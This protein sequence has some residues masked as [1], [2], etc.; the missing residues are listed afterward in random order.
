MH[1]RLR[2]PYVPRS[3]CLVA[4][5][6]CKSSLSSSFCSLRSTLQQTP[7]SARCDSILTSS[8]LVT[9]VRGCSSNTTTTTN[10]TSSSSATIDTTKV[11]GTAGQEGGGD[12]VPLP[13]LVQ[14]EA[15]VALLRSIAPPSTT[16]DI[17]EM[18]KGCKNA[19][20]VRQVLE[21]VVYIHSLCFDV[22]NGH[23]FRVVVLQTLTNVAPRTGCMMEWFDCVDRFRRLGFVLTRSFVAEGLT[24]IR[25]WLSHEFQGKGRVPSILTDGTAHIKELVQWCLEDRLVFDHVL[26]TRIV[27]LLTMIVSFFDRQNLYR[28]S[29]PDDF[30]KRDGIVVEWVVTN[31]RCVDYDECVLQCDALV[32][33]LLEQ[34]RHHIPSRPPF[35]FMFRL[36][37][38]YFATDNVEKLIA[39]MEDAESYGVNVAESTTA[40]L[41]QL[42]CAFNYPQVPEL[43]LR[44]RVLLPQCVLA[45]PDIS[46]LLFYFSRSGGGQPCPHCGEP[47][48]HRN[49]S[50]Y[51]WLQTPPHQRQ[52]PALH[53]ARVQKGELEESRELPQNADWSTQA[54]QL[55]DLSRE[56]AIEWTATEWRGFLLCCMFSP[57]ALEAKALL[58]A[59]FSVRSMD[60][61]LRATYMRLLRHHAPEEAWPTLEE[62]RAQQCNMS[63]IALQEALMATAMIADAAVRVG[64]MKQ[65]WSLLMEKNSYVM[66]LTRR[67]YERR[68]RELTKQHAAAAAAASVDRAVQTEES[69]LMNLV[70]TMLP[71]HVSLLDMK[72]SAADFVVGTRRKNVYHPPMS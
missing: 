10:A 12:S 2:C 51:N 67:F 5:M 4:R 44:W 1:R 3:G 7:Q 54:F 16:G 35:S 49:S 42:A 72:D 62:W 46:R 47:Y 34:M 52:C 57:R 70:I 11:D 27:F 68:L 45:T 41:M 8:T 58:N 28:I 15:A 25:Q 6:P 50:V 33:E 65:V 19:H 69:Q 64:H 14:D 26:Y 29:F 38:Y 53:T 66:P 9:A 13:H 40:K 22:L 32:E 36:A 59:H 71:R 18:L 37:D 30:A 21:K 20:E 24:T 43:L 63:P 55:Y 31:E 61:F 17:Q 56:R 48:N 23:G 39:V 60:D